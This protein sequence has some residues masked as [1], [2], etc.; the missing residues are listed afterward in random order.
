[1]ILMRNVAPPGSGP[2]HIVF[3]PTGESAYV[4]LE[5]SSQVMALAHKHGQL[6]VIGC[7][8][9][10][11][12]NFD[13]VNTCAEVRVADGGHVYVSNR[14]HDSIAIFGMNSKT[15]GLQLIETVHTKGEILRNFGV[16]PD[17]QWVVVANQNSHSLVSFR[18]DHSTGKLVVASNT[19]SPSPAYI[20]FIGAATK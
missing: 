19:N 1:M 6:T 12:P 5:L 2:R 11:P 8:S 16:S 17:G 18:R 20:Y 4:S 3:S 9:T 14:G 13:G 10:L 7:Y 15:R